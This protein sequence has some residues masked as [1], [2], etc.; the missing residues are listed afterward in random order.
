MSTIT[1][2]ILKGA[3]WTAL[4]TGIITVVQLVQFA[5]LAKLLPPAEMAVIAAITTVLIFSQIL[6]DMGLG[7][8]LIQ[9][10]EVNDR[11]LSSLY[12]LNIFVGVLLF[13]LLYAISPFIADFFNQERLTE[14]IRVTA[15]MFLIAP[16]GQQFQYMLQKELRFNLL[17]KIEVVSTIA[18]FGVL[19]LFFYFTDGLMAFAISQLF[20]QSFKGIAFA[21]VYYKKW[22]P[23]FRFSLKDVAPF[24]SFGSFQLFSRLVNRMGSNI[25]V[26]LIAY[27]LG[28]RELGLY[29]VAY[30]LITIPVLKLNPIITRVAFPVFAKSKNDIAA[31]SKG[32]LDVTKMLALVT[33]PMLAGLAAVS[34]VFSVV[35]LEKAYFPDVVP[36]ICVLA[37]VGALR[38]LMNPNGSV[39]LAKGRADLAF[40]WDFGVMILYGA[41]LYFAALTGDLVIVSWTY[42]ATSLINFMIGRWLLK[43]LIGLS[44]KAYMKT[45]VQPIIM[46]ALMAVPV[47]LINKMMP[48]TEG[49]ILQLAV[50]VTAGVLI[51]AAAV[52]KV[53]GTLI[54]ARLP[55]RWRGTT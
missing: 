37:I 7:A 18:S 16:F 17:A 20:L 1:G 8:A 6:L 19:L 29:N 51:Y 23:S 55:K 12:W 14:L 24:L 30:Q 22:R 50:C 34:D 45:L 33:F 4:S 36:I 35:F 28:N 52:Y 11:E 49:A 25:D 41:A 21:Y 44:L 39:I 40:Y 43:K 27:F 46:T 15:V 2:N 9:K 42:V 53:Y 10:D 26:F 5:L 48:G 47:L 38:V 3:K 32:F 13:I 54:K 31:V